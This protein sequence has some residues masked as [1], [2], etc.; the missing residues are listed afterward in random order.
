MIARHKRSLFNGNGYD[1][2]WLREAER[3]GLSNLP[4]TP[5]CVP[6]YLSAKNMKLFT[7]HRVY[8]PAELHARYE[9]KLDTYNKVIRIEA[10]TMLN[11]VWKDILPAVSG[12]SARLAAAA[13]SKEA[14]GCGVDTLFERETSARLSALIRQTVSEAGA[15]KAAAADAQERSDPLLR[16]RTYHDAVLPAM[17]RLRAAV[18]AM[19]LLCERGVWPYP[20]YGDILFS[21]K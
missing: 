1:E 15:L 11:M 5:D 18:D 8:T 13:L 21:V 4:A 3:R 19:E 14:L 20:T 16:A 12:Y 6:S 2:A 7:E 10:Q 9:I 17:E